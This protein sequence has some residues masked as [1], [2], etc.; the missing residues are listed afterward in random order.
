MKVLKFVVFAIM[1]L[2]GLSDEN[3]EIKSVGSSDSDQEADR[4]ELVSEKIEEKLL[5]NL[6]VDQFQERHGMLVATNFTY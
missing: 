1:G 6:D 4:Q 2:I 3:I 5:E